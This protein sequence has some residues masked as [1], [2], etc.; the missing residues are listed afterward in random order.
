MIFID[1]LGLIS[2]S[3]MTEP[4][5]AHGRHLTDNFSFVL[6]TIDSPIIS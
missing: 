6:F 1:L 5:I 4:A 3:I 2:L